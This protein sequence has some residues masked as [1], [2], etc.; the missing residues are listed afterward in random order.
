MN[1]GRA[2]SYITEDPEWLKKVGIAMLVMLIPVIGQIVV[3]GWTLEMMRRV[4]NDEPETLPDWDDFGKY[5]GN[6]FK[7]FVVRL[8]YA[9][10]IVLFYCCYF[11]SFLGLTA[12]AGNAGSDSDA[13]QA[14]GGVAL[15]SMICLYCGL[16]VFIL[17][18]ALLTPP[19]TGILAATGELGAALRIG[20]VFALLRAAVGPYLLS[21]LILALVAPL[22]SSIGSIACG[23]GAFFALSYILL[24]S[25]HLFGQAYKIAKSTQSA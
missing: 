3:F 14:L 5:L 23:I 18:A 13:G 7:E 25:A 20:N 10:P 21:L 12:V 22:A 19:A 17:V 8:V 2:F 16:F 6:G 11:V 24:V 4:I 1:Y 15:F 9:L